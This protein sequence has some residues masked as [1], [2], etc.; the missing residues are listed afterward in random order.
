MHLD[1]EILSSDAIETEAAAVGA[2][3]NEEFDGE[4][5]SST[6]SENSE[7]KFSEFM[8]K[9]TRKKHSNH[10]SCDDWGSIHLIRV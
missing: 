7:N 9:G 6:S 3:Q 8:E 4:T 1:T 2:V 5:T 10:H